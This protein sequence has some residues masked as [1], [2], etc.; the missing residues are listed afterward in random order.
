MIYKNKYFPAMFYKK[1]KYCKYVSLILFF[2]VLLGVGRGL[3]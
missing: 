2:I 3:C 1:K